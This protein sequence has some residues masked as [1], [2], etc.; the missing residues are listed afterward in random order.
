MANRSQGSWAPTVGSFRGSP[1][2]RITVDF[3]EKARDSVRPYCHV[4]CGQKLADQP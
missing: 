2:H 3:G 4:D 1:W